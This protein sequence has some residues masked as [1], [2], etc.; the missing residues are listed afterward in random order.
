MATSFP[1]DYHLPP[2][3]IAQ[4]PI[5]PRDA[6]RMLVVDRST[7]SIGHRHFR[8]LPH[9]LS[10]AD[11]LVLNDTRVLPAR[12]L[13]RRQATGGKWEG[14]FLRA[15]PDGSWEML[16]QTRG[17]LREGEVIVVGE[18]RCVGTRVLTHLGSPQLTLTLLEKLSEGGW[19]VQQSQPGSPQ[20][21]L[22]QF[23]HM[24]LPPYIRKGRDQLEDRH[25]YQTVFSTRPGAIAAPT[26][27]LHFTPQLFESLRQRGI[28]WTNVT[29]HVGLG[30]F[31]PIEGDD[32]TRHSMHAEWGELSPDTVQSIHTC[33]ERK[34]RVVAVGTTSVRVLETAARAGEVQPWSGE[35]KLFIYPP[36]E[37]RAVDA[38][39]TNFHLPRT[40]LLLLV[41]AF[42]GV[43]LTERAYQ[44]A[45]AQRYRFFSYGDA[46]IIVSSQ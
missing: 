1:V 9:L 11:L 3:L 45:I 21:V 35:T 25:R 13:G 6:A 30:T 37:F 32:F 24:P 5:E 14:L 12:L 29:L 27:G 15:L 16:C 38:L 19:R 2:E 4:H 7:Q 17:K 34:G 39:I 40:T 26:A 43:E 28:A 46:M 31:R 8:D 41:A 33:K 36:Y 23:G 20:E 22:E 44:E 10:P 18:P 42:A